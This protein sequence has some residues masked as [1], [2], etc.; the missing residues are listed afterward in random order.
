[1]H[2]R[3]YTIKSGGVYC[4]IRTCIIAILLAIRSLS[5]PAQ[6]TVHTVYSTESG[7]PSANV[8]CV[9]QDNKGYIWAAA[10][11][12]VVKYNGETF[13]TYNQ[14]NGFTDRGAFHIYRDRKGVLWFITFNGKLCYHDGETFRIP[15]FF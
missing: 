11:Y 2:G 5:M 1:M 8:Y 3:F 13:T 15:S 10:E 14:V 4:P 6:Q 7:L 9:A 12:G